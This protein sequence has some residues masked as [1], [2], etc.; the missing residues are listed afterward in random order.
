MSSLSWVMLT[1]STIE[2][3]MQMQQVVIQTKPQQLLS[4]TWW[5]FDH[6]SFSIALIR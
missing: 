3:R 2:M 5:Y 6:A 4:C 1:P